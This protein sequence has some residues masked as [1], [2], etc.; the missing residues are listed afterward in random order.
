[1]AKQNT[2]SVKIT[3]IDEIT[4]SASVLGNIFGVT[5]RRIR[6]M[7]EEGIVVRAAKGRYRL[8]DSL[9]NYILTLKLAAEGAG[10]DLTDGEINIDEEKA[11]HER[12]KRHISELKLQVMKGSLHE[13]KDVERVMMDMLAAFKT[14]IMGIPS[15]T[16]PVLENRDAAYIKDCMTKEVI[17]ALNELA[18]YD[19]KMFY[20]DEYVESVEENERQ[21]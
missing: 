12:V 7:S 14:K 8:M 17:D 21:S 1:M 10:L 13:A 20:S 4:V 16:A 9:R 18:D 11:L 6:Q 5:D 3:D 19:P 15:K 2:A